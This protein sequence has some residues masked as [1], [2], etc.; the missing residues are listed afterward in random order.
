MEFKAEWTG[1]YPSLCVGEWK[2]YHRHEEYLDNGTIDI[3]YDDI[4]N[5]I[6]EDIKHEPMYTLGVYSS[7]HFDSDYIKQ[8]EDYTDGMNFKEWCKENESWIHL[9]CKSEYY[10]DLYEAF[11][12]EDWRYESCGGCI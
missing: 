10:K 8:F 11:Q 6:P 2:L 3:W 1:G 12:Q 9:I 7:W 5:L 4:S